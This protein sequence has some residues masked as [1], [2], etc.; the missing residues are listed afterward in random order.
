MAQSACDCARLL[1]KIAHP[2]AADSLCTTRPAEN[3]EA[4][5]T[6]GSCGD[7]RTVRGG[8]SQDL[9]RDDLDF[10]VKLA[11][12]TSMDVARWLRIQSV[13]TANL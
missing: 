8:V 10:K 2:N 4:A 13:S 3:Y 6:G 11:L 7:L 9:Y 12:K 1:P 5:L